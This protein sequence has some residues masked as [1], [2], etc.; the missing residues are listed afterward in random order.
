MIPELDEHYSVNLIAVLAQLV[1]VW[2]D[3]GGLNPSIQGV[4]TVEIGVSTLLKVSWQPFEVF[5][6]YHDVFLQTREAFG[7]RQ[8]VCW[9]YW[10]LF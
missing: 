7:G 8:E 2:E 4:S 10:E 9:E 3:D 6:V 1:N 5:Q